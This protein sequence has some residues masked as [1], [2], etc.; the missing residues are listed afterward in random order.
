MLR[1]KTIAILFA[2][3]AFSWLASGQVLVAAVPCENLVSLSLPNAA[4]ASARTVA[5]GAF[6][7]PS[8]N[9][10][11]FKNLPPFCRVAL[12]LKPSSDSDIRAEVWMPAEGWNGRFQ[13][14]GTAGMG[15]GIPLNALAASLWQGYSS[16]G[17]T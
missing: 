2:V 3:M 6:T 4:V 1:S 13:G 11:D 16:D 5:A 14:N 15:G 12:T 10:A 8:G 7:S 9:A 17:S